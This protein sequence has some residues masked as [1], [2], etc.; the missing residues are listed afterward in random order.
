[1]TSEIPHD[2]LKMI[3]FKRFELI[4][5]LKMNNI[6]A[7]VKSH[8]AESILWCRANMICMRSIRTWTQYPAMFISCSCDKCKTLRVS[9][10]IM[11]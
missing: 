9:L 5:E 6:Q 2:V 8:D 11:N 4:S 3:M 10:D 1:M 7:L